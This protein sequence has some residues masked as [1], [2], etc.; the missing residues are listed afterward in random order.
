M[1]RDEKDVS[2]DLQDDSL[3]VE[4]ATCTEQSTVRHE[5][6]RTNLLGPERLNDVRAFL[7]VEHDAAV[8]PVNAMIL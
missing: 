6:D 1:R 8:L 2:T 5:Q 4:L 3:E 7:F